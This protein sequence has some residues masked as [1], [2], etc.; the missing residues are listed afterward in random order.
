M[1]A[2]ACHHRSP[3]ITHGE[4]V[5]VCAPPASVNVAIVTKKNR[6]ASRS[7]L[8]TASHQEK[9]VWLVSPQSKLPKPSLRQAVA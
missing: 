1:F 2:G 4:L 7:L 9:K 6:F 8:T 5:P 3:R